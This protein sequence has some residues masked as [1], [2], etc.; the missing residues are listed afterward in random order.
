MYYQF[1]LDIFTEKEKMFIL[2]QVNRMILNSIPVDYEE[3][4]N[5]QN[6]D[7]VHKDDHIDFIRYE[8]S[9]LFLASEI[10]NGQMILEILY[11]NKNMSLKNS[12]LLYS[13]LKNLSKQSQ[14]EYLGS[15]MRLASKKDQ[16]KFSLSLVEMILEE[17][18]EDRFKKMLKCGLIMHPK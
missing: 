15:V 9:R 17:G 11:N 10:L 2:K 18:D 16:S 14:D 7:H 1:N 6:F 12:E 13:S 4:I 3:F 5:F 8:E